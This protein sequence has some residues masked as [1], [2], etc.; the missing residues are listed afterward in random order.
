MRF[1]KLLQC[2]E[3]VIYYCFL[4]YI[5]IF[6]YCFYKFLLLIFILTVIAVIKENQNF[7]PFVTRAHFEKSHHR[8]GK[9]IEIRVLIN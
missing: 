1:H 6:A 2:L 8:E 4:V 5:D 7:A 3:Y 9:V